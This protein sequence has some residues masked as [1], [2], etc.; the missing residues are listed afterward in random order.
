MKQTITKHFLLIVLL[1][2][3]VFAFAM[4]ATVFQKQP[5][6]KPKPA[7]TVSAE[8]SRYWRMNK[9]EVNQYR[10]EQAYNGR[11]N[12]GEARLIFSQV[13][14]RTDNQVKTN[15]PTNAVPALETVFS[16]KFA[17]ELLEYS[18]SI[19]VFTPIGNSVFPNTLKVS[20]SVQATEGQSYLQV[21]YRNSAYQVSG[22]SY[23][24][25]ELEEN[26]TLSKAMLEDELWNRIRINPDKLPVGETQLIPGTM[27][28]R[29]RHKQLEPL[30]AKATL[31]EYEGVLYPG[32]FLKS[33]TIEYS[34]D[35]RTLIIIFESR[36][37][38]KIV[39]WEE[40]YDT[41]DNLLTSRAVLTKTIQ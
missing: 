14:F 24:E 19:S 6:S 22:R 37:P 32:Q 3:V 15:S 7:D 33:Y 11:L 39:G 20:N 2:A 29:L 1:L 34:T 10:L 23:L 17:A 26:Y 40:T 36:F 25:N 35:D 13:N 30:P 31:A 28:A 5:D 18:L 27:T 41:K 9:A 12:P 21:N 38:Y 16:K 4:K 8:F